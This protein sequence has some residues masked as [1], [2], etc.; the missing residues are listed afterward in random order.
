MVIVSSS[1]ASEKAS[2][3]SRGRPFN[4]D[5]RRALDDQFNDGFGLRRPRVAGQQPA[6]IGHLRTLTYAFN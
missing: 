2:N 4:T 3:V 6:A 1:P 5:S